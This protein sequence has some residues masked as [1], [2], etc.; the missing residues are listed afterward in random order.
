V[1]TIPQPAR[2]LLDGTPIGAPLHPA[3]TDI[4][5]GA[6]V[7]AAVLDGAAVTNAQLERAA[8]A[9]LAVAVL[10]ALPAALTGL[11]DWSYLRGEEK[12]IGS[13][14]ALLNSAALVLN[15]C[16]LLSR[17]NGTRARGRLL[18]GLGLGLSALAAHLG[19]ELSFGRGIRVNRTAFAPRPAEWKQVANVDEVTDGGLHAATIDG[20]DVVLARVGGEVCAIAATCTHL[21]GPLAEGER[22][23]GTVVCPWHGSRFDLCSGEVVNGPAVYP[24]PAY[25]VRVENGKVALRAKSAN[26]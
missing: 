26:G 12:R 19:G 17:V 22:R 7:A 24:Q 16:S 6:S 8:D 9:A 4:P 23:D 11:N 1:K 20:V 5:I 15:L 18:S 21:G 14:H 3:L 10:G 13:A 2:S 25:D